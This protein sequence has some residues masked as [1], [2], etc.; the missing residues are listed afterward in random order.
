VKNQTIKNIILLI[1]KEMN[2]FDIYF[3]KEITTHTP[4]LK[5]VTNYI[6][7]T[8]G[9]QIR[10]ILIFTIAKMLGNISKKTYISALVMQLIHTATLIH[11]DVIDDTQLRRGH[12]SIN[13]IWTNKTA[14]LTGDYLL[15]K[16]ILLTTKHKYYNLLNLISKTIFYMTT[17]EIIQLEQIKLLKINEKKYYKIIKYKTA[18]LI[19]ACGE[20]AAYSIGAK[21][22]DIINMKKLGEYIGMAFQIKNDLMEYNNQINNN[23]LYIKIEELIKTLP[24]IH[25]LNKHHKK[26]N[27]IHNILTLNNS[28]QINKL[29]TYITKE[30]GIKYAKNKIFFFKNKALEILKN[31][32]NSIFKNTLTSIIEYITT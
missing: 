9:K 20:S 11:D 25:V 1:K 2:K 21:N 26:K 22:Q 27:I 12:L 15:A 5:N 23:L 32:P 18:M 19:A 31:Y 29:I 4:I 17:G 10:P 24:L 28:K 7:K 30:G 8:K 13:K 14:I 3:N 16:C 6:I